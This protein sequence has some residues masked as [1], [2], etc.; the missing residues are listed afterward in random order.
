MK[1]LLTLSLSFISIASFSQN[2]NEGIEK[3]AK[4]P[5]MKE[6]AAK[7]D[8]FLIDKTINSDQV[9]QP[10]TKPVAAERIK[11]KKAKKNCKKPQ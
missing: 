10:A 11:K 8:V 9:D 5:K 6:A 4:D 3:A 1:L 2:M 7:A